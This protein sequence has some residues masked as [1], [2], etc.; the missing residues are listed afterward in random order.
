MV[1]GKIY[2]FLTWYQSVTTVSNLYIFSR[3]LSDSQMLKISQG[4]DCKPTEYVDLAW[5]E[6][7]WELHGKTKIIEIEE[8]EICN[9]KE[10]FFFSYGLANWYSCKESCKKVASEATM[11]SIHNLERH[12]AVSSWFKEKMFIYLF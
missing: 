10:S 1:I 3:K 11:P 9:K 6:I 8:K 2:T 7:K 4:E 12:A 5:A